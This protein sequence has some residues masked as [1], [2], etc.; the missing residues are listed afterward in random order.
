MT[1]NIAI[2]DETFDINITSS[3]HLAI[4]VSSKGVCFAI[5]DTVRVKFIA[6]KN[7][8]FGENLEDESL[9]DKLDALF[10]TE[11]YLNRNYR[12][13]FF[14]FICRKA[15]LIPA[16]IYVDDDKESYLDFIDSSS[17][18]EIVLSKL[19]PGVDAFLVYSMPEKVYQLANHHLDDPSFFHQAS[20][21]IENAIISSKGKSSA[22]RVF[23]QINSNFADLLV[24]EGGTLKLYNTFSF[25]TLKDLIFYILYIYDQF[26]L[27]TQQ[28]PLRLSG[29]FTSELLD[30]LGRY[31]RRIEYEEFNRSFTYSYTF[32]ELEQHSY[33]NLINMFRCE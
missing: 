26:R 31:I 23:I 11:G 6:F 20:P 10:L 12:H 3:Y 30:Q 29:Y 32:N 7:I 13:L 15:T 17:D 9:F 14:N 19:I 24:I 4:Q 5:L 16:P 18:S 1:K 2:I 28:T 8:W 27:P 22:N 33:T 25:K 21:F